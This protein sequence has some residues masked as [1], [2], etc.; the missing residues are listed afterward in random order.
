MQGGGP[1]WD[2]SRYIL[3]C[4]A[5]TI[6]TKNGIVIKTVHGCHYFTQKSLDI[7]MVQN[8]VKTRD[9]SM[10]SGTQNLY[11]DVLVSTA[12]QRFKP[13]VPISQISSGSM[14]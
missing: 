3:G 6:N 13:Q 14:L 4:N 10:I 1:V 9:E 5:K 11:R 7:K 12:T 8:V 2:N